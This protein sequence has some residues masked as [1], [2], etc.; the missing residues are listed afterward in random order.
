MA[1]LLSTYLHQPIYLILPG[2]VS[3]FVTKSTTNVV[4]VSVLSGKELFEFTL[5]NEMLVKYQKDIGMG[6]VEVEDFIANDLMLALCRPSVNVFPST[7]DLTTP[8]RR[9]IKFQHV[10]GNFKMYGSTLEME[11]TF[12]MAP[13]LYRINHAHGKH[14][15]IETHETATAPTST[16]STTSTTSTTSATSATST[17]SSTSTSSTSTTSKTA[18]KSNKASRKSQYRPFKKRKVDKSKPRLQIMRP[19]TKK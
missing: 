4:Y 11:H 10:D 3:Y 5:S 14:L 1:S 12:S 2:G 8:S 18:D 13:L 6:H 17:T 9:T 16:A 19:P 15:K 7:D